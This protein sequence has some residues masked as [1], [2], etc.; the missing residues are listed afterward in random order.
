MN[1]SKTRRIIPTGRR[2][3]PLLALAF[4]ALLAAQ[5]KAAEKERPVMLKGVVFV[6]DPQLVVPGGLSGVKGVRAD[7]LPVFADPDFAKRVQ[8]AFG[9]PISKRLI[10]RILLEV[11]RQS[12]A[13]RQPVVDAFAPPQNVTNGVLQIVV[14]EGKVGQIKV[15]GNKEFSSGVLSRV[16]RAEPGGTIDSGVLAEDIDWINR[17]PFRHV[18]LVYAKGS[19]LGSTD[20]VLRTSEH[21]PF[22]FYAGTDNSGTTT[23][24]ME[25]LTFGSGWGDVFGGDGQLNYQYD[26]SPDFRSLR[27]HSLTYIQPL[28]WRSIVSLLGSYSDSRANLPAPANLT[29]YSWQLSLN[30]EMPLPWLGAYQHSVSAGFDFKRSN[31]NL[32]FGGVSVFAAAADVDQ[33]KVVYSGKLPD[34]LGETSTRLSGFFSPGGLSPNDNDAAYATSRAGAPA[35]Y[36]YFKFELNRTTRLFD[37][38]TLANLLTAQISDANLLPSEQMGFGGFDTIRGVDTRVLNADHGYLVTTEVRSPFV[39]VLGALNGFKGLDQCQLYGFV[40]Y[41]AGGNHTLLPGERVESKLLSVGPGLRYN[42]LDNVSARFDFG[43]QLKNDAEGSL[44]RRADLGVMI[45][46]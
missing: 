6:G 26:G 35:A 15:E 21:R 36:D 17:N 40:D 38:W 11:V 19:Q 44:G 27:A 32:T 28:P 14:L 8:P 18:D 10:D 37:G 31:N 9:Q 20:L 30:Y 5:P 34:D 24:Q 39:P 1:S 16:I 45:S 12:R 46:Y 4:V 33:F 43:W 7:G 25:R 42:I 2:N 29:G 41:G 13:H 3:A 23:T 22:R